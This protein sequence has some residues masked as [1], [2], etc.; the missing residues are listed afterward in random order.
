MLTLINREI[1][2]HAVYIVGAIVFSAITV[3]L[4][5]S[6]VFHNLGELVIIVVVP[7]VAVALLGSASLGASQMYSDRANKIT[8]FLSML[9]A[10]RGQI[11][12]ARIIVGVAT[13]LLMLLPGAIAAIALIGH[14]RPPL[15]FYRQVIVEL[16]ATILL[17]ILNCYCIGLLTGWTTSKWLPAAGC[18]LFPL[19]MVCLVVVKGFGLGAIVLLGAL[20][21][22]CL[23]C[24]WVKFSSTPL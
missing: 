8:S 4:L 14:L 2:D 6:S 21:L 13:I 5:I 7:V 22:A 19:V 10:S 9:A 15:M 3:G 18:L 11:L 12:T 23:T 1:H 24:V 17:L 20:F 16:S